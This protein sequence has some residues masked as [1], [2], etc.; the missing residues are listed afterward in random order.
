MK[1]KF[2]PEKKVVQWL[3]IFAFCFLWSVFSIPTG[4]QT[5]DISAL[6]DRVGTL[7]EQNKFTEALPL[8]E[9]IAVAEPNNADIQYYLGYCLFAKAIGTKDEPV[10]RQ[11]RVR[12]RGIFLKAK[13][14]GKKDPLLDEL[15]ETIPADGSEKPKFS[16]NKEANSLMEEGEA[17][18]TQGKNDEALR[19]YQQAL[20]SD[21]KLYYAAL[22]AGDVYKQKNDF[23]NAEIWYQ[24]AIA[25]DPDIETAYR[26]S[27]TP[28]M[29]QGKYDQAR[30]RYIEAYIT[31]PFSRLSVAGL[32]DWAKVTK[33]NLGHPKITIPTNPGNK[34]DDGSAA[35][36]IYQ[37]T[38]A[39]WKLE[40][41]GKP[42]DYFTKAY[43][44]EAKYRH[45]L[46]EELD[47]LKIVI[48]AVKKDAQVKTLDPS[49]AILIELHG[50]GL[51]EPYI[52]LAQ[53]DQGIADDYLL[54]LKNNRAK[55]RQYVL[56]YV[57]R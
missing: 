44:K 13:E 4:A 20:A 24:R 15:I 56:E 26:Y 47:A 32:T 25:I 52:L 11:L 2:C 36:T 14:L 54:Y 22:F 16:E 45:S 37:S 46:A 3:I 19:F 43:P 35:W 50:K 30:D 34:T 53:T 18:F 48:A 41:A 49:L 7:L 39:V 31:N 21:P 51:L 12:A 55:L 9:K 40:K 10:R 5:E 42:S 23:A 28:L 8:L 38:R 33:K 27:A 17:A 1:T 6:K 57:I 29:A